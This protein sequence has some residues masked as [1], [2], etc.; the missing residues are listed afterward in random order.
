M[1]RGKATLRFYGGVNEIGGNKVLLEDSDTK[2]LIDFG[3]SFSQ[4]NKY[5][6]DP[7]LSPKNIESLK[8]LDIL[9]NLKGVYEDDTPAIQAI[10]LSHAHMDH[11]AH[12]SFINRQIPVYC[13]ETTKTILETI[14]QTRRRDLEFNLENIQFK[15]FR[16]KKKFQIDSIEVEPIHVDHSIPGAYGFILYTST[17][18]IAYTGDFRTHGTKPEMTID[19]IEAAKKVKPEAIIPEGTNMTG[20]EIAS[21]KEVQTKLTEII[22]KTS[23]IVIADFAKADVDRFRSFYNASK[24]NERILVVTMR[25]AYMLEALSKDKQLNLPNI[26]DENIAIFK[27]AKKRHEKWEHEFLAKHQD[28]IIDAAEISKKQNNLVLTLSFFDFEELVEIKPSPGSCY[29]LSA[30]EPFN[31]EMQI[32]YERLVNWLNH[33]GLPQYHVHISGHVMPLQLRET[34]ET[35]KAKM[36]FPIHGEHPEL[37]SKFMQNIDSKVTIVEKEKEYNI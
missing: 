17:G 21:E 15:T 26:E 13:G 11:A 6:S 23:G 29:I 20:A 27:K 35:I 9:P 10:L 28:K 16:T 14:H 4:R 12:I 30:S 33:F 3:M 5:Y 37:F 1:S 31:E 36:I 7:F 34:M 24:T 32:D 25:Q 8:E 18:A 2:I 19:F 22:K